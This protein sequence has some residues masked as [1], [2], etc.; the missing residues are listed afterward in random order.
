MEIFDNS[1]HIQTCRKKKLNL[2]HNSLLCHATSHLEYKFF[3][4]RLEFVYT[5]T[6]TIHFSICNLFFQTE[7]DEK[8]SSNDQETTGFK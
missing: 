2:T 8:Q 1:S 5:W 3:H 4:I 6:T 7:E